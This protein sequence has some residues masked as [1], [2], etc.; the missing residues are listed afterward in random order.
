MSTRQIH[1]VDLTL[2][3]FTFI[4]Y[5]VNLNSVPVEENYDTNINRQG[6][7]IL[8]EST[9]GPYQPTDRIEND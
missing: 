2:T 5:N 4:V 7:F 1:R 9:A 6:N 8:T 3:F